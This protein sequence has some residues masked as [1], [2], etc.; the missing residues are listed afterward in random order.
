MR[1][2]AFVICLLSAPALS[3]QKSAYRITRTPI[4]PG[5]FMWMVVERSQK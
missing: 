2:V 4:V 1:R 3:A 5:S